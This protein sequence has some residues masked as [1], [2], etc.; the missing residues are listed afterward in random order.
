MKSFLRRTATIG[1]ACVL[2]S[3]AVSAATPAMATW[4]TPESA[5]GV[6]TDISAPAKSFPA[7]GTDVPVGAWTDANHRF[8]SSKAYFTF[9]LRPFRGATVASAEAFAT[10]TVANDCAQ[11]RATE[12]WVTDA[13]AHPTWRDQPKERTKLAGP[14][15]QPGCLWDRVEWD[16]TQAL[17]AAIAAGKDSLTVVLRMPDSKQFNP[18][19][20]RRVANKLHITMDY[21]RPPGVPTGLMVDNDPCGPEPLYTKAIPGTLTGV[22]P[23]PDGSYVSGK[24]T[25][26][27]A[28][29]PAH[30][31][32]L[33]PDSR[34]P[35]PHAARFDPPADY[36]ADGR[37]YRWTMQGVDEGALTGPVSA[38]C[39]FVVDRTAPATVPAVTSADYPDDGQYHGGQ[40]VPGTF[41]V[42]AKGDTDIVSFSV[43]GIP[44]YIPADR[45]GGK[46]TVQFTPREEFGRFSVWGVDRARNLS[47]ESSYGFLVNSTS[48]A[49][50]TNA[51]V[52]TV[53]EPLQL[54]F[55]PGKMPGAIVEYVYNFDGNGDQTIAAHPDGTAFVT[56]TPVDQ[57][58]SLSV[59]A[60]TSQ[61]WLSQESRAFLQLG[62]GRPSVTSTVYPQDKPGGGPGVAGDFT[63]TTK[64][65]GVVSF[66]YTVDSGA[67]VTVAARE[68]SATIS[69]TPD[70]AGPHQL[71]VS[72]T[73][74]DGSSSETRYYDF[75]VKDAAR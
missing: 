10:E 2:A 30:K 68:G 6:Y 65:S 1:T 46:A 44:G 19:Y 40:G 26:W 9:D 34:G 43:A 31:L 33:G 70:S 39:S 24:V 53:G 37:T 67:P 16:A 32:E 21:N 55:A 64:R 42:D 54:H 72:S 25:L 51:D 18:A 71:R 60:K 17:G 75:H 66:V 11:A 57:W 47:P 14:G 5:A 50:T 13:A 27:P 74:A 45:P 7:T 41:V 29:D 4:D 15:A 36:L 58:S 35:A 73:N 61:G 23:D 3:V 63:F 38:P 52:I 62:N 20:G 69:V 48:P 12:L 28:D 59:R 22:V 8:H 49:V 56:V